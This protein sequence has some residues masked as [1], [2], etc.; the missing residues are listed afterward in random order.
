MRIEPA[1]TGFALQL[2]TE[3]D[4]AVGQRRLEGTLCVELVEASALIVALAIDPNA[5]ERAASVAPIVVPYEETTAP[6]PIETTS[7]PQPEPAP[8]EQPVG[9]PLSVAKPEPPPKRDVAPIPSPAKG[10]DGER[11]PEH[12]RT[13]RQHGAQFFVRPL[14]LL[15]TATLP[16][17][18]FGPSLQGGVRFERLRLEGGIRYLLAQALVRPRT[19]SRIG[20]MRWLS[21]M[22]GVCYDLLRAGRVSVAPCARVELGW[23]WGEGRNLERA[24][25]SGGATWLAFEAGLGLGFEVLRGLSLDAELGAALPVLASA[26]TVGGVGEVHESPA[27]TGRLSLGFT[28]YL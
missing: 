19:P 3:L 15:D 5:A 20:D 17:L 7:A 11:P 18:A 2:D 4:G 6:T 27:I 26:F 22:A 24:T 16:A 10:Y 13:R 9:Q 28:L 14:A 8:A 1:A 25:L 21:G 12:E 23:L